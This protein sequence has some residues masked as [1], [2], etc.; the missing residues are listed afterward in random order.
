VLIVGFVAR[1]FE[2]ALGVFV[3]K[4]VFDEEND[5]SPTPTPTP[6]PKLVP[7]NDEADI[8]FRDGR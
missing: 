7:D 4:G 2:L 1:L 3:E 8:S 5:T 6:R